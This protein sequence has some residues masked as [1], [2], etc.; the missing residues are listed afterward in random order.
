M[1]RIVAV[2]LLFQPVWFKVARMYL[3]SM[4]AREAGKNSPDDD[5]DSAVS[6]AV[7]SFGV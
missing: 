6:P 7:A 3:R 5:S 4:S 1:P 2:R